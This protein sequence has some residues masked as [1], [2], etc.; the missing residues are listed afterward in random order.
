MRAFIAINLPNQAKTALIA[1]AE[2]NFRHDAIRF[3]PARNLHLTLKFI[4]EISQEQIQ[5]I[6]NILP[7]ILREFRQFDLTCTHFA[8]LNPR[9]LSAMISFQPLL[10]RLQQT[11]EKQIAQNKICPAESKKF[12][13]HLTI[14][15][16][17]KPLHIALPPPDSMNISFTA[18]SVD[19]MESRLGKE[20]ATYIIIEKFMLQR[21]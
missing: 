14:A 17:K 11:I 9:I 1:R 15:R 18:L 10:L 12:T 2:Q 3:A 4:G 5:K 16:A 13:P 21:L 8:W 6:K 20:S 7:P 19:L